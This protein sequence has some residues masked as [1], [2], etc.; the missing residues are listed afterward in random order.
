M[1]FDIVLRDDSDPETLSR[2]V[3]ALDGVDEITLIA[4][5]TDVDY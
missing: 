1:T 3:A 2:D 4:S 5:K